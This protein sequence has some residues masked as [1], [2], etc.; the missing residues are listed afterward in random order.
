M[1]N[2]IK[3]DK[4]EF[5]KKTES[6]SKIYKPNLESPKGNRWKGYTMEGWD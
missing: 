2:L 3:N 1:W 5:F 6:D 4:E